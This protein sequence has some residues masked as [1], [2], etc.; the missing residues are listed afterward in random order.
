VQL[1]TRPTRGQRATRSR[2]RCRGAGALLALV[3]A[4]A[5]L[6]LVPGPADAVK[7]QGSRIEL[8]YGSAD[9]TQ[10]L[11]E[12]GST[13]FNDWIGRNLYP[14]AGTTLADLGCTAD[15]KVMEA[16]VATTADGSAERPVVPDD[17]TGISSVFTWTTPAQSP[18][19]ASAASTWLTG[20]TGGGAIPI[21][22]WTSAQQVYTQAGWTANPKVKT[23]NI[24][25]L[26]P[27]DTALS[28]VVVCALATPDPAT[29]EY[30]VRRGADGRAITSWL[31][32]VTTPNP[33]NPQ[34]T[35]EGWKIV[36]P[37]VV[38]SLGV[39]ATFA[40][41]GTSGTVTVT[42]SGAGGSAVPDATG[43]VALYAGADTSGSPV[44]SGPVTSSVA[45]L[46]VSGLTPGSVVS[47]TAVYTPDSA[48]AATYGPATSDTT[49]FEVPVPATP[50][51]TT[52][53]VS[54]PLFTG[55]TQTLT[56]TVAPAAAVGTV[57]FLDNGTA[58]GA[59]VAVAGGKASRTM[60]LAAGAHS[61]TAR[62]NPADADDYTTSTSA[63]QQ[64]AVATPATSKVTVAGAAGRYG[65]ATTAT[66][67]VAGGTT[68]PAGTVTVTL[69]GA[70][71]ASP[72]LSGGTAT[73]TLPATTAAGDH[74][75]AA[76]YAGDVATAAGTGAGTVTIAKAAS[77][78]AVTIKPKK[79]TAAAAKKGKVKAAIAVTV[80]GLTVPATG[81]VTVT[82]GG[83]K[84]LT[85]TLAADG[86]VTVKLPKTTKKSIKVVVSYAGTGN[87]AGATATT[88]IK[89]K[90]AAKPRA[91]S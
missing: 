85:A 30:Y 78:A 89:V 5:G 18:G 62:F 54:G 53:A 27:S 72:T 17:H 43:T 25:K 45:T 84:A 80:P 73:V 32:F 86:T 88:T 29:G 12:G 1:T 58:I 47:Y 14:I 41:A 71:L 52:L 6:L 8:L 13:N 20:G 48:G 11:T 15:D 26:W 83:G 4:A 79:V 19:G 46:P 55:A 67:T 74:T 70:P 51:T 21:N 68:T 61:L 34:Y 57:T 65:T 91:S 81:T 63:A 7:P 42:L 49:T 3:V 9:P 36:A 87:V 77:A 75:L 39:T 90:A 16:V 37:K 66:V 59:P 56:A 40:A 10:A 38:P 2:P 44:A 33:T 60:G 69:D 23:T 31:N 50:T 64:V 24:A 28:L 82:A 76:S 35:S 22:G